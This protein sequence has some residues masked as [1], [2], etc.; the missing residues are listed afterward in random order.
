MRK[1]VN[2]TQV[3]TSLM[4]CVILSSCVLNRKQEERLLE[5]SPLSQFESTFLKVNG[6][7]LRYVKTGSG[8]NLL[9]LHTIRT[10]SEY[11]TEIIPELSK[12]YTVHILDMPGHGYSEIAKVEYDFNFFSKTI[13]EAVDELKLK[14]LTVVGESI[15]AVIALSLG[16]DENLDIKEVYAFNPY[17]YHQKNAGGIRRSSSLASA[18]FTTMEW[19]AIGWVVSRAENKLVLK[20]ILQGGFENDEKLSVDLLDT[21]NST[22]KRKGYRKAEKNVFNNWESW[23]E[24]KKVYPEV[25]VPVTLIYGEY[26]WSTEKE[27]IQNQGNIPESKL[28]II[29]EAGHFSALD[30]PSEVLKIILEP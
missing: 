28:I 5:S 9:L 17:D 7:D 2:I 26:D 25:K 14:R 3:V 12:N 24:A 13:H 29:E 20:K 4:L 11:F 19:P 10:Q 27:R 18:V 1:F 8:P 15:G 21:F 22:G 16:T 6:V 30:T 23:V